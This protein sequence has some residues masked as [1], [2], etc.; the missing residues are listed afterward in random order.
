MLKKK[1]S[2]VLTLY[3]LWINSIMADA[4]AHAVKGELTKK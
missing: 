4:K 1:K 2:W 3:K